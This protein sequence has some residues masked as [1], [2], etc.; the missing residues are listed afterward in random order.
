FKTYVWPNN[1]RDIPDT[2]DL[3]LIILKDKEK[4][5]EIFENCGDRPRV[6]RN[7]LIFLSPLESKK[8]DFYNFLKRKIAW[9]R[10][11]SDKKLTLTDDQRREVADNVKKAKSDTKKQ[12]RELYRILLI[13]SKDEFKEIDLGIPTYG[14]DMDIDKEVYEKLKSE[15]ELLERLSPLI[16]KEKYLSDNPYVSTK[17]IIETFYKTP[18][19][20]RILTEQVLI[21][22]I[23]EGVKQGLFGVGYL[24]ND[25]PIPQYFKEEFQPRLE[26]KE[27]II[28]AELCQ[29]EEKEREKTKD[30]TETYVAPQTFG[31]KEEVGLKESVKSYKKIQLKLKIQPGKLSDISR[32][33]TLI[34]NHFKVINITVTISA[35]DGEISIEDY[36]NKIRETINQAN[37]ELE[38]EDLE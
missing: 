29:K 34:T 7:T 38:K 15:S 6:H 9:E 14:V 28:K 1:S 24:E 19:E 25:V 20:I 37:I 8:I 2:K 35:Q 26:E 16:I 27:I 33:V 11:E 5:R 3:K 30:E 21:D 13:P 18:G 36:E 4:S 23:K 32:I 22:A 17:N 12:L 31:V 10:I